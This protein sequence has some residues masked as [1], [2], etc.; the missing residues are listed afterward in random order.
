[1]L[2]ILIAL[3]IS[4]PSHAEDVRLGQGIRNSSGERL[5]PFCVEF[6]SDGN[7][8]NR[9]RVKYYAKGEALD[10]ERGD[11]FGV[12][13]PGYYFDR[14]Q[15]EKMVKSDPRV[16]PENQDYVYKTTHKWTTGSSPIRKVYGAIAASFNLFQLAVF[17]DSK[18]EFLEIMWPTSRWATLLLAPYVYMIAKDIAT[19][20]IP[21]WTENMTVGPRNNARARRMMKA[22]DLALKHS[23]NWTIE[24]SPIR[25]KNW[26]F[27]EWV[28][29]LKSI[30]LKQQ[31][32]AYRNMPL[33]E[34]K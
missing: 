11:D 4:S 1:V 33:S 23:E 32:P 17:I 18:P 2:T 6:S 27:R 25:V 22:Y 29:F 5:I 34:I 24:S 13:F 10:P 31:L 30:H 14:V 9:I 8:C 21:K 26:I 12:E 20:G 28:L 7:G 19:R 3:F 16:I 15:Y